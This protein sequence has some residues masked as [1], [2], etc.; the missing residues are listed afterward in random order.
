MDVAMSA[1]RIVLALVTA[2]AVIGA[3]ARICEN[4]Y[5]KLRP[6]ATPAN[7]LLSALVNAL[8][9]LALLYHP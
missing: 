6:G 5:G 7:D 8:T 1:L 4:D 9:V 2:V 3:V